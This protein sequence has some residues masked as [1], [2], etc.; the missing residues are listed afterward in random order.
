MIDIN[1]KSVKVVLGEEDVIVESRQLKK[2]VFSN[3]NNRE[4]SVEINFKSKQ[5]LRNIID[6]LNYMYFSTHYKKEKAKARTKAIKTI[7]KR[8]SND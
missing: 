3:L 4:E 8:K 5:D 7:E 1:G 6:A 2:L